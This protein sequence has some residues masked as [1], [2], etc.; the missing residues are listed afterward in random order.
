M[1]K[2]HH[3]DSCVRWKISK[4][5]RRSQAHRRVLTI[6]FL[7]IVRRCLLKLND[8]RDISDSDNF[9]FWIKKM[10]LKIQKPYND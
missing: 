3:S 1:E 7:R 6:F 2:E 9:M 4:E 10:C 5:K 8:Q